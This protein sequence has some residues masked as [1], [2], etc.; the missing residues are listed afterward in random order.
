MIRQTSIDA[1]NKIKQNG[2]LSSRRWEVYDVLFKYG[3]LTG[4]EAIEKLKE[5]GKGAKTFD[6]NSHS[7][8]SE[9]RQLG[10][11]YEV[12]KK[13]CN[14]TGMNV[15]LWDVTNNLPKKLEKQKTKDQIIKEL[16]QEI[17][18]LKAYIDDLEWK[19]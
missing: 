12:G 2:S 14:V 3:P 19:S 18:Q 13:V 17:K 11:I 9:L 8:L 4:N 7:R 1:Y 16:Q 5:E 6:T 10:V 15:I